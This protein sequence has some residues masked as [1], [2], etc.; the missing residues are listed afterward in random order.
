VNEAEQATLRR[1]QRLRSEGKGYAATAKLLNK[2]SLPT[3]RGG[4][5]QAM[6]VRSVLRTGDR[7][8]GDE[9]VSPTT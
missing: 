5:W 1:I 2:K 7:M 9:A 4:L 6:S 3:K 8:A